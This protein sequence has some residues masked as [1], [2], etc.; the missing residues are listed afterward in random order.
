MRGLR[1]HRPL[2]LRAETKVCGV[3]EQVSLAFDAPSVIPVLGHGGERT[4]RDASVSVQ[5][6]G[7]ISRISANP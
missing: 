6:D 4:S 5:R 1:P 3:R 2:P 7:V